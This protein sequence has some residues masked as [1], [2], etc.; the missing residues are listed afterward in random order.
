MSFRA[1]IVDDSRSARMLL[2]RMLEGFGLTVHAVESAEQALAWLQGERPDVIFMDHLMPGMDGFA[3]VKVIKS[4]PLTATIPVLM[5]TSQEGELYLS[6]ARALGAMGV[7]PKTLKA[8]EVA[9]V[10]RQLNMLQAAGAKIAP[11]AAETSATASVTPLPV[12]PVNNV[13]QLAHRIAM[14]LS[15]ELPMLKA[16]LTTALR[17]WRGMALV[18]SV[19]GITGFGVLGYLQYQMH[20]QLLALGTSIAAS[21]APIAVAVPVSI[22][23]VSSSEGARNFATLVATESVNYGE[24]PLSGARLE[25]LRNLV[26]EQRNK[27]VTTVVK[28]AVFSA[29]FCLMANGTGYELAPDEWP[30]TR[31]DVIGNPFGNSLGVAQRQSAAFAGFVGSVNEGHGN[32]V[33]QIQEGGQNTLAAYPERNDNVTAG[34]WN[35]AAQR[36]QRVEYSIVTSH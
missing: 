8:A 7:L 32:V 22:S 27:A 25:R 15:A 10:L 28:L 35:D 11:P 31:C 1:L 4:D 26:A 6:Q 20:Q 3:A 18:L 23:A 5:Y 19:L 21:A 36:N 14:E 9:D 29:D 34:R 16:N 12:E 17:F 13:A 2:G 33:I 30:V 24:V